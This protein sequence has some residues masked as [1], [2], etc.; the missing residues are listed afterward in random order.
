[1]TTKARYYTWRQTSRIIV[2]TPHNPHTPTWRLL[3]IAKKKG[4]VSWE[5]IKKAT[6]HFDQEL[7]F[8]KMAHTTE[9]L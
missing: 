3:Y 9:R 2:H 7:N 6:N 1:L 5:D 4:T 8:E